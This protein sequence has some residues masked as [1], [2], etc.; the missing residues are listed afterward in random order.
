MA[1]FQFSLQKVLEVKQ[2]VEED[3]QASLAEAMAAQE[4]ER[5]E[6]NSMH[7]KLSALKVETGR[8][9]EE[10][11]LDIGHILN[12]RNYEIRLR[13][14]IVAQIDILEEAGRHVEEK[15]LELMEAVRD[16]KVLEKLREKE[17]AKHFRRELAREQ[18]LLDE[19]G[20]RRRSDA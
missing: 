20:L 18:S 1:I 14:N 17:Q 19:M 10:S 8:S 13:Q 16:R 7:E 5:R 2:R 4:H 12:C 9:L 15:R 6:L 11:Q 3:R